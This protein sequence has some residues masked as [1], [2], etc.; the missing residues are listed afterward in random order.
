MRPGSGEEHPMLMT[1]RVGTTDDEHRS[2]KAKV[3]ETVTI[4]ASIRSDEILV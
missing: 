4:L 3:G 2:R 1:H